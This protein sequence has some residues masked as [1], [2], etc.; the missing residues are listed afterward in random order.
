MDWVVSLHSKYYAE[1][2]RPRNPEQ[3]IEQSLWDVGRV[4]ENRAAAASKVNKER[5]VDTIRRDR[6]LMAL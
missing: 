3:I 6:Y 4:L 5:H 1:A 2:I